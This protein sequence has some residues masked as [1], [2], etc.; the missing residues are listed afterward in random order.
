MHRLGLPGLPTR[1]VD[2]HKLVGRKDTHLERS[3]GALGPLHG[4]HA[5]GRAKAA[6][7]KLGLAIW[8]ADRSK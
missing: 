4:L 2:A 5:H 6:H 7:Q 8:C 3:G 1:M